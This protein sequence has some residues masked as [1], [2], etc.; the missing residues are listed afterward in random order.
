M[1]LRVQPGV[2]HF[3]FRPVPERSSAQQVHRPLSMAT[4]LG[5]CVRDAGMLLLD[6]RDDGVESDDGA[7]FRGRGGRQARSWRRER[8]GWHDGRD[9]G[10]GWAG[11]GWAGGQ[12][13]LRPDRGG[14]P[15]WGGGHA[16]SVD[17]AVEQRLAVVAEVALHHL[18]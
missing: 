17:E 1:V 7:V 8:W 9:W 12:L 13:A 4:V 18:V 6:H 5:V 10:P 2:R 16:W 14:V 15:S 11:W 3:V